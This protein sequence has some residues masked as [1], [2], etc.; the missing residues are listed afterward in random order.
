MYRLINRR[1]IRRGRKM[2]FWRRRLSDLSRPRLCI[3]RSSRHIQVQLIDDNRG[4]VLASASSMETP[5]RGLRLNGKDMAAKVGALVAE[6][7]KKV[8]VEA[9]VF[10]RNGFNYHGR[11]QI[12]ADSARDAGLKF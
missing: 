6:R 1:E 12:L 11:V 8:N 10:D 3:F 9:V 7:A 5:L 2:R 4:L